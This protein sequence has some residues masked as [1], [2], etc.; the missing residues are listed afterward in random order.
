M[1]RTGKTDASPRGPGGLSGKATSGHSEHL[2]TGWKP[3]L[4][5]RGGAGGGEWLQG[6]G[7]REMKGDTGNETTRSRPVTE[8]R[9]Q[10]GLLF[11]RKKRRVQEVP[12]L[13][14]P[15]ACMW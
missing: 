4:E 8:L 1:A 14:R 15:Q 5:T 6:G 10:S 11:Q 2:S 12:G 9:A 13:P 3:G 7:R